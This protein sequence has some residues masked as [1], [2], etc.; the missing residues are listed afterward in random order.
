MRNIFALGLLVVTA[1]GT[2]T[3]SSSDGGGDGSADVGSIEGGDIDGGDAR[4]DG[5]V[6]PKPRLF[7]T[8]EDI[9]NGG[10]GLLA[11]DDPDAITM[12]RMPDV[13]IPVAHALDLAVAKKRV[14]VAGLDKVHVLDGAL[15]LTSGS[16]SK[17]FDKNAFQGLG[18]SNIAVF[19]LAYDPTLDLLVTVDSGS[20]SIQSFKGASVMQ[21]GM[22]SSARFGTASEGLFHAAIGMGGQLAGA[23]A[24]TTTSI[25][26]GAQNAT[27]NAVAPNK[28]V[29]GTG[30]LR[31]GAGKLFVAGSDTGIASVFVYTHPI[32]T[33][34]PPFVKLESA[35]GNAGETDI[36]NDVALS[37]TWMAVSVK[38]AMVAQG[39]ICVFSNPNAVNASTPCTNKIPIPNGV[40]FKMFERMGKLFVAVH[41]PPSNSVVLM[42][43][44]PLTDAT[45]LVTF[46]LPT[47][48]VATGFGIAD[49]N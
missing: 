4:I 28:F 15:G 20:G 43:K 35:F 26:D 23:K 24:T 37:P 14:F 39:F 48:K 27:G 6:M 5:M 1:C 33:T 30:T 3:F 41:N 32:A 38:K 29:I 19:E 11:W 2:E 36:A 17:S 45:P 10:S 46:G 9:M 21:V 47:N 25:F 49:P 18:G 7:V 42:F 40:P 34:M 8:V 31:L 16:P 44:A 13:N 12:P 22:T